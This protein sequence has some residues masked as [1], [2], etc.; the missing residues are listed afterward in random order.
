MPPQ[1]AR[2]ARGTFLRVSPL[3]ACGAAWWLNIECIVGGSI[4]LDSGGPWAS[5][6]LHVARNLSNVQ[7]LSDTQA[8]FL[9]PVGSVPWAWAVGRVGHGVGRAMSYAIS[10]TCFYF[11]LDSYRGE[12][13]AAVVPL[14]KMDD[15]AG[16]EQQAADKLKELSSENFS[17]CSLRRTTRGT[18]HAMHASNVCAMRNASACVRLTALRRSTL[19]VTRHRHH[20]TP[21]SS[22]TLA[23][24]NA[25]SSCVVLC[26][27][28]QGRAGQTSHIKDLRTS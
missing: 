21:H 28:K 18:T 1:Q 23:N 7:C 24:A 2:T 13:V 17:L 5:S 25:P 6:C 10:C 15:G 11:Y 19:T 12:G 22:Q 16:M 4:I 27:S 9:G 8:G 20:C 3:L 26:N 14:G